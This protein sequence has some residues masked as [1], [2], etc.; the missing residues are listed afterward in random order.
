MSCEGCKK[1]TASLYLVMC[2]ITK[3]QL[4]ENIDMYLDGLV[5]VL[6]LSE[7]QAE[8]ILTIASQK[9]SCYLLDGEKEFVKEI[10]LDLT[11]NYNLPCKLESLIS[12]K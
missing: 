11:E 6:S 7:I 10:M 9:G 5:S 4:T 12:K 2:D 3:E 1:D 8:Q